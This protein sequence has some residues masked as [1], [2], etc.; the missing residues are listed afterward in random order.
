M[1]APTGNTNAL[2]D[3]SR[4]KLIRTDFG[5]LVT[6]NPV[7]KKTPKKGLEKSSEK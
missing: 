5:F 1:G 6:T 4:T 7:I 2:K 3:K